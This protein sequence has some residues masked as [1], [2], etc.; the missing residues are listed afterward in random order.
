MAAQAARQA[1]SQERGRQGHRPSKPL[2]MS[3]WP[4]ASHTRTP[5]ANGIIA[6]CPW[7]SAA[8]AADIVPAS[9]GRDGIAGASFG[10]GAAGSIRRD[11]DR[12]C[13]WGTA[14][15]HRRF[16]AVD[17]HRRRCTVVMI[18]T[19]PFV[20]VTIHRISHITSL[21]LSTDRK[22]V[23]TG[24]LLSNRAGKRTSRDKVMFS[25]SCPPIGFACRGHKPTPSWQ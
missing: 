12:V 25:G 5:A 15:D 19:R 18:S 11:R 1:L 3:V 2:R 14:E 6:A 17:Q 23:F 13:E 9:T 10:A 16:F 8:T 24:R 20:V 21:Q 7:A 22:A 4:V